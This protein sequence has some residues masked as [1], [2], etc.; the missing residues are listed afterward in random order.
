[1]LANT[2]KK[3][4][5]GPSWGASLKLNYCQSWAQFVVNKTQVNWRFNKNVCQIKW[6]IVEET[7]LK[8]TQLNLSQSQLNSSRSISA[9]KMWRLWKLPQIKSK[10]RVSDSCSFIFP[11][12][13]LFNSRLTP[14]GH[15]FWMMSLINVNEFSMMSISC[16]KRTW[17]HCNEQMPVKTCCTY[18]CCSDLRHDPH[19]DTHVHTHTHKHQ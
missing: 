5:N 17:R 19:T 6:A 3:E 13:S 4:T 14:S 1:M 8:A 10:V 16:G 2:N 11:L 15:S 18:C 7:Q 9:K 12:F